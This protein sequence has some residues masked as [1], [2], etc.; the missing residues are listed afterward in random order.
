MAI[1]ALACSVA[2]G[3][4]R[5]EVVAVE[6]GYTLLRGGQP[7]LVKGAGLAGVD[8]ATLAARGGNSI[9]T[10]GVES[11]KA[12]LDAAHRHGLTVSLGLPVA[13]E[14]AG[15]DYDDHASIARQRRQVLGAVERH[16]DHPALLAWIIGNEL[17]M[18]STN[19]RVYDEVNELARLI[20]ELDPN[21]PTTTTISA[22]DR[23]TVDLVRERAPDLDFLSV[24]AYGALALMPSA[25]RYLGSGPFMV[26]EW[27]PLGHWEVAKTRWGAPIE[28]HSTE[29]GRHYLASYRTLIEPFLGPG[30]GSYAFLW[31]QKQER[32]HT[33]FSLF[34]ERGES[35]AAVDVLQFVWTG[36]APSNQAPVL[37]SLS[38]ARRFAT[39]S[40]RLAAG[41]RYVAKA[42]VVDPD[43][44]H[45]R[46]WWRVKPESTETAVGGDLEAPIEDVDGL[47][48]GDAHQ[49][50]VVLNAPATAGPYRLYV[51]AS[52]G[53]GHAA[54]AN[55]PFLVYGKR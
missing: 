35:T 36:R 20:H 37:N 14:R 40:I 25:V 13:P 49:A 6:A 24:Q 28:Q 21:H 50:E 52:D 1:T 30:L 53:R 32:T 47:F 10:W 12:T 31:G 46:Y 39:D 51:T 19:P 33:W 42:N 22:L 54:Y 26:T 15:F 23:E 11:A 16:K 43:G 2:Y 4:V 27:G 17:D 41:R 45:V 29:K 9:R 5:V 18:G 8:V 7:Y 48:V 55:V 34:T 3:A 38:L 44:D